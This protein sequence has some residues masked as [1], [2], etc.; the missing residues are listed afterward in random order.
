MRFDR[1]L[2]RRAAIAL[3]VALTA[4][5]GGTATVKLTPSTDPCSLLTADEIQGAL[6]ATAASRSAVGNGGPECSWYAGSYALDLAITSDA[7]LARD[8]DPQAPKSA[9]RA[10]EEARGQA[11]PY[12]VGS[13][14]QAYLGTE[15]GGLYIQGYSLSLVGLGRNNPQEQA[16]VKTLLPKLAS[17]L[18]C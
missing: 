18:G 12:A 13:G 8:A 2:A 4:C 7:T 14:C 1:H 9:Q 17:R 5:G 15:G 16:A 6:G 3:A 11:P 10:F